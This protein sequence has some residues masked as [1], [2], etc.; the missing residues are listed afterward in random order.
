MCPRQRTFVYKNAG[1]TP[2]AKPIIFI[3]SSLFYT[4]PH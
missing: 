3:D 4:E 2:Q 1:M